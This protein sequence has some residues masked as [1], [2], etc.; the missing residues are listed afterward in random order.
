M[1]EKR[2]VSV[3]CPSQ[4]CVR[5]KEESTRGSSKREGW[6]RGNEPICYGINNTRPRKRKSRLTKSP[7]L[8]LI[9]PILN[10]MRPFKNSKL[11]KEIYGRPDDGVVSRNTYIS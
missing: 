5:N 10:E 1:P 11:Y 2:Q 8:L 6:Q 7:G 3:R 9:G 4:R